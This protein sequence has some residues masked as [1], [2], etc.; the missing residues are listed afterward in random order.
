MTE[1]IMMLKFEG[2]G[3]TWDLMIQ[4]IRKL[5]T[6]AV[7]PTL[8]RDLEA[9]IESQKTEVRSFQRDLQSTH[10]LV[11]NWDGRSKSQFDSRCLF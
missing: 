11:N 3:Q 10:D 8:T 1:Q 5:E 4:E 9:K 7:P 2:I 6:S